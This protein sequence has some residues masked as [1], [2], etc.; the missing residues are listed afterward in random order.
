[1]CH[2]LRSREC[3]AAHFIVFH[4]QR[5]FILIFTTI[6]TVCLGESLHN[7]F[8]LCTR[9]LGKNAG[10]PAYLIYTD[11]THSRTRT[12]CLRYDVDVNGRQK[13]ADSWPDSFDDSN[14]RRDWG[15]SHE[16]DL[17][18]MIPC[19]RPPRDL[20]SLAS[21]I[22]TLLTSLHLLHPAQLSWH[23]FTRVTRL[24]SL[25]ISSL[26]SPI[27]TLSASLHSLHPY[28]LS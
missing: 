15:W 8:Q 21:P 1:M 10:R 27:L 16:Y 24:N 9:S 19:V 12:H 2:S 6:R 17:E 25:G 26:A 3:D 22:M 4:S 20:S 18:K 7:R 28:Q 23:L 5:V 14:A 13:I 11:R